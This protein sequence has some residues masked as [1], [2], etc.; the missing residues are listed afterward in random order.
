MLYNEEPTAP[1]ADGFYGRR[2]AVTG[3]TGMLGSHLVAELLR[4]GYDDIT[5]PVRNASRIAATEA[6]L[7][8]LGVHAPQGALKVIETP[9]T[10][11]DLLAEKLPGIDT[12]FNCAARIMSDDMT[13]AQLIDNNVAIARSVTRWCLATGVRKLI[14][15]SSISALGNPPAPD[16]PVTERC[17]PESVTDYAAYGQ[18][19]Y[20]SE[21]EVWQ[22]AATGLPTIVL[23][24]GV[25]LGEGDA[26]GN[27][28]AALIP[29]ISCGQPFYTD[30]LMSY[31]DVRDV[32]K[33]MVLLDA[34][35]QAPG[36]R[37]ILS[38]GDMSYRELITLGARAAHRPRPFIRI[39]K[40]AVD[41]AYACMQA[42]IALRLVRDRGVTRENLG[43]V[44][45]TTRY[46]GSKI[47]RYCDFAYTP[48]PETVERVVTAYRNKKGR[49]A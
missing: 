36:E 22:G 14:H 7:R 30:G 38:A 48:L 40:G 32:A 21:Q 27:N 45:R 17:E 5:L 3:A 35:P 6:T 9:L 43:S 8:R 25:I 18:S 47:T 31:V 15:V 34:A 13:A 23:L 11:P 10:D 26:T 33:A 44:L 1:S 24:P 42:A 29:A 46:D 37:F 4:A 39:G 41:F 20:Y 49:E 2:I 28:S 16:L 19:K 12:V